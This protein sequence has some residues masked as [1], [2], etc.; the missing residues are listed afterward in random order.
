MLMRMQVT[1]LNSVVMPD[2]GNDSD[3]E[4]EEGKDGEDD[5]EDEGDDGEED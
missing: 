5:D 4:D 1:F 3:S 2:P